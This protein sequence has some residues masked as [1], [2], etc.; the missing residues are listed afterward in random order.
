MERFLYF[1]PCDKR[2]IRVEDARELGLEYMLD[3]DRGLSVR[4]ITGG[5]PGGAAGVLFCAASRTPADPT[6]FSVDVERQTWIQLPKSPVWCGVWNDA[7]PRP[8]DL[9]RRRQI[10]GFG[11]QI[12]DDTWRI[13]QVLY[14][15]APAQ[16]Y[17]SALPRL[18]EYD[19]EGNWQKGRVKPALRYIWDAITP[20]AD[21]RFALECDG[22]SEREAVEL[23]EE[24]I[25]D[26][27]TLL[28]QANY[29]VGQAELVLLE[30]L[31]DD[32]TV[33]LIP[34]EACNFTALLAWTEAQKKSAFALGLTGDDTSPGVKD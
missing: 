26:A 16:S 15:D 34:M 11:I 28:L 22:P 33:G 14:F 13:P 12:G 27:A 8:A 25:V 21:A 18:W 5:G 2:A 6:K 3:G 17:R 24:A 19:E 9:A 7:K 30:T 10:S 29:V 20:F 4:H 31:V 32:E 23:T 1:L